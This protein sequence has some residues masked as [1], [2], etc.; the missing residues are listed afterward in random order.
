M[1]HIITKNGAL[2]CRSSAGLKIYVPPNVDLFWLP[3]IDLHM[4]IYVEKVLHD[5]RSIVW[6]DRYGN[7]VYV[8]E[9][10]SINLDFS[11]AVECHSGL[12]ADSR[13]AI[14]C[15]CGGEKCSTTHSIWCPKYDQI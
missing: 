9:K 5:G 10:A 11:L 12:T 7:H 4:A 13:H 14:L 3:I 8:L 6:K 15:E 2:Y 1:E